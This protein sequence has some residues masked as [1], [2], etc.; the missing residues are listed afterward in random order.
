MWK[1]KKSYSGYFPM[2]VKTVNI[3]LY[4]VLRPCLESLYIGLKLSLS[5][6]HFFLTLS[7]QQKTLQGSIPFFDTLINY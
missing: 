4:G 5:K 2:F 3:Y 6:N 7:T 1:G